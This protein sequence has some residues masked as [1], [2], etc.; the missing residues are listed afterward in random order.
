LQWLISL[1]LIVKILRLENLKQENIM[2]Y[3]SLLINCMDPRLQ[4]ENEIKIA[5]S[6]GVKQG[7][8][9]VLDYAGPSLWMTNPHQ[10]SHTETFWWEFEQVSLGVHKISTVIIVGHSNCG[11]FA[12]KGAPANLEDERKVIMASLKSARDAVLAKHPDKEVKLV[13]VSIGDDSGEDLPE[14]NV[15]II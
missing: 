3:S 9:E 2:H 6:C 11:G 12:L 13:F 5:A 14:I 7:E 10:P 1:V 8:Y 4:G 15:Q